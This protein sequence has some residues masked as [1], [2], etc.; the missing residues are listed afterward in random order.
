MRSVHVCL[1]L[2]GKDKLNGL[3]GFSNQYYYTNGYELR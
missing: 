3:Y 1:K 2:S